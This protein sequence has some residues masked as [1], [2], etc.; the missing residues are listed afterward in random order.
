MKT[1]QQKSS[2]LADEQM[3]TTCVVCQ[4]PIMDGQ[5]FCRVPQK[6]E[7]AAD[8]QGTKILLCSP[9]CAYR[10]FSFV[11]IGFSQI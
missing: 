5:W 1:L 6:N 10:Y 9:G 11:D 3:S 2:A 7:R 4:K 8:S